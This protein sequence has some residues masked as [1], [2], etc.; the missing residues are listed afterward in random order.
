[1]GLLVRD[2]LMPVDPTPSRNRRQRAGVT[3]L[4]RHLPHHILA[5]PRLAPD[6]GEAEEGERGTIRLRMVSPIWSVVAEIDEAR[7]VGME[8]ESIPYKTLT[9][10]TKDPLGIEEFLERHHGIISEY[11]SP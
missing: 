8:C 4:C 10:N 9:Q 2:G 3:V 7:L 11:F 5:C 6:V 1:M